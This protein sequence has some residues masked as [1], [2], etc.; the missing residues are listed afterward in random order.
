M[1]FIV[2]IILDILIGSNLTAELDEEIDTGDAVIAVLVGY[3]FELVL[4]LFAVVLWMFRRTRLLRRLLFVLVALVT[5]GLLVNVTGL[6]LS[7]ED[8]PNDIAYDLLRDAGLL[9]LD[10]VLVFSIWY[11]LIDAGGPE[12]RGARTEPKPSDFAFPQQ[13][14]VIPGWEAWRSSYFDYLF[15][16][17]SHSTAFSPTDTVILSKKAKLLIMVQAG[18]SLVILAMIAARAINIIQSGPVG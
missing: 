7:L 12:R 18:I 1:A 11:W 14:S 6:V 2:I 3:I 4:L 13:T 9:W 10:N 5:F 16:A 8:Y 17:F 15:L